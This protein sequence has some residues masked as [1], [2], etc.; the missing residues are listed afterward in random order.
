MGGVL[1]QFGLRSSGLLFGLWVGMREELAPECNVWNLYWRLTGIGREKLESMPFQMRQ[2]A[3][4]THGYGG[5]SLIT[6]GGGY[7]N[8][9]LGR[10]L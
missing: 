8:S 9:F 7:A 10:F 4:Q 1:V 5:N 6:V 3:E 2:Q